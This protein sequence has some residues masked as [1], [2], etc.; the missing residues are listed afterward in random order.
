MSKARRMQHQET[1]LLPFDE[2][3]EPV[4]GKKLRLGEILGSIRG[5]VSVGGDDRP[6]GPNEHGVLTLSA[7]SEGRFLP[8]ENKA[9]EESDVP[10]LGPTVRAR[11]L[12]ISRSNTTE[13]VGTSVYVDRDHPRL[14]LPDLIWELTVAD[15]SRCCPMWLNQVLSS[16]QLRGEIEARATGT[17]GSMKK[18]SMASLRSIEIQLPPLAEQQATATLLAKWDRGI[19]LLDALI[20]TKLRFKR[21][22]MQQLFSGNRRFEHFNGNQLPSAQ[23][24]DVFEKSADPVAVEAETT[25]REIGIRSH[26]KGI[27]HKEPVSGRSLGNKRVYPVIPG[28][29]TLNI[30]FAW[31]R[32][33]AVTTDNEA[34]MIASHRFP[35]FRP[36]LDRILPGYALLYLLSQKGTEALQLASPGGAG[37]NRTLSQTEFLK[38]FVPLPTVAE[39]KKLVDFVESMDRAIG[40]LRRER[41]ALKLQKT[42]IMQLLMSGGT[43]G[44]VVP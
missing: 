15:S 40:L 17:S 27:F 31:E 43:R 9:V 8:E 25:Y 22:M 18:L 1:T 33:L 5:G 3:S 29:L 35:M 38:T 13:L 37:R 20:E 24:K 10:R 41:R 19:Q 14:H 21:G 30:V 44:K 4:A 34:G 39:Q 26:G 16:P 42:G 23:L 2:A 32:A 7:V 11:T 28:C 12:L 6:A 36:N